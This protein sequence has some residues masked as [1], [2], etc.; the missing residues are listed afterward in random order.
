MTHCNAQELF[1]ALKSKCNCNLQNEKQTIST[2]LENRLATIQI[3]TEQNL[4]LVLV[5]VK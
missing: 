4:A 2:W 3:N 5:T 1:S